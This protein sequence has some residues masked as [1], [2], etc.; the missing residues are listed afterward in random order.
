MWMGSVPT[1][2][3]RLALSAALATFTAFAG[4][5]LAEARRLSREGHDREAARLLENQLRESPEDPDARVLYGLI[6]SWNRH[7]DEARTQ[8]EGVLAKHP[9][10]GDAIEGLVNLEIWSGHPE[11]AERLTAEALVRNRQNSELLFARVRALRALSR[12]REALR[13]VRQILAADP[14]NARARETERSLSEDLAQ[15]RVSIGHGYE[16]FHN[17]AGAWNQT[18]LSVTRSTPVGSV[19][20]TFSR[21]ERFGLHSNFSEITAYPHIRQG[22][23]AY[24]G[25]GY[26]H[27]GTLFPYYRLGAEVFQSLPHSMEA[28]A[29]YRRFGFSGATNMYT[30]SVGRYAGKWLLTTRFFLTP[31][32]L[33]VSRSVSFS[34]RRFLNHTGDYLEMRVGTGPSPFDPRNREELAALSSYSGYLRLRKTLSRHLVWSLVLG[35]AFEDRQYRTGVEHYVAQMDVGYRF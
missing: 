27:D 17:S 31:G 34:A 9:D 33:G 3:Y 2:A 20:A 1:W 29:G 26:S 10:Y 6:L 4:D 30:G 21:A 23:Y 7:Y 13:A 11:R 5:V 16:W 32:D 19:S 8:F 15:T 12:D 14:A 22:T 28:S 24:L 25:Y 35:C 18:D